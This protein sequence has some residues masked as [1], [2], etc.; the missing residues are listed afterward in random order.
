MNDEELFNA[1]YALYFTGKMNCIYYS[2][3]EA[4]CDAIDLKCRMALLAI[5]VTSL[6]ITMIAGILMVAKNKLPTALRRLPLICLATSF[7]TL[8]TI[9]PII[10]MASLNGME[11]IHD[12]EMYDKWVDLTNNAQ[13]TFDKWY[14]DGYGVESIRS[15]YALNSA[16]KNEIDTLEAGYK[17][18]RKIL[19]DSWQEVVNDHHLRYHTDIDLPPARK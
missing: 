1:V 6:T 15:E 3:V 9:V 12:A 4:N 8:A 16:I 13:A 17:P 10:L 5:A 14:K 11:R 19:I 2:K 18:D 7:V